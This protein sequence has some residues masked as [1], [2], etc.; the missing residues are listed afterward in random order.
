MDH[1]TIIEEAARLAN[2][3]LN[4]EGYVP[5][6]HTASLI[7]AHASHLEEIEK[8][9]CS[10]LAKLQVEIDAVRLQAAVNRSVL[11]PIRR[12]PQ[13]L[14]ADIFLRIAADTWTQSPS[15]RMR[16]R[17]SEVCHT[18]R[19]IALATPALWANIHFQLQN[20]VDPSYW[21]E[22]I[23]CWFQRS[24]NMPIRLYMNIDRYYTPFTEAPEAWDIYGSIAT[25]SSQ[26]RSLS[27]CYLPVLSYRE[28]EGKHWPILRELRLDLGD[29]RNREFLDTYTIPLHA[30]EHAPQLQKLRLQYLTFPERLVVPPS[31]KLTHLSIICGDGAEYR[32]ALAP[33]LQ[34]ILSCAPHLLD[35]RIAIGY[36]D[37][38]PIDQ[39]DTSQR[40]IF[41]VLKRLSLSQDALDF[42]F[43]M[44]TPAIESIVLTAHET[45]FDDEQMLRFIDLLQR[46]S[47]CSRLRSLSMRSFSDSPTHLLRCLQLLPSLTT[48][49]LC[50]KPEAGVR[51][52]GPLISGES[53][54]GLTRDEI[55]PETLRLLP[56]LSHLTLV[57]RRSERHPRDGILDRE[58]W[59]L[60]QS[61]QKRG[62][63]VDGQELAVVELHTDHP[64]RWPPEEYT[65][66]DGDVTI[67]QDASLPSL[68]N[69]DVDSLF[70]EE[71]G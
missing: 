2:I 41:P 26:L 55:R 15:G 16:L 69:T 21:A 44:T 33:C 38:F 61:R 35:C 50:N 43:Y 68:D 8:G 17:V 63:F 31:W 20:E 62:I 30:F 18:W 32:P 65:P 49:T 14:L 57:T 12:L 52:S 28:F 23:Q 66:D 71:S 27:L 11:A 9:L 22:A 1:T 36:L 53:L 47:F 56:R 64:G 42:A 13:E 4:R 34:A 51:Q 46:S 7:A 6:A 10:Q 3:Q 40:T 54:R 5:D 24:Q 70:D 67:Y 48:L 39:D 29:I 19:L 60:A 45:S 59:R 37:L 58:I 25:R